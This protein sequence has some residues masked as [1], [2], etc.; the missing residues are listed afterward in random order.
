MINFTETFVIAPLHN[1]K[2]DIGFLWFG[3]FNGIKLF[4]VKIYAIFV[5]FLAHLAAKLLPV[6]GSTTFLF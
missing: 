5:G 2:D 3:Y 4:I 1:L 6:E